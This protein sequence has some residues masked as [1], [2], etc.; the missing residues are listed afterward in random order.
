ME[1]KKNRMQRLEQSLQ[2]DRRKNNLS[3]RSFV[4]L[5]A[6]VY[7]IQV[8]CTHLFFYSAMGSDTLPL[9]TTKVILHLSWI[10]Q[11]FFLQS[12]CTPEHVFHVHFP[13]VLAICYVKL[14]YSSIPGHFVLP[15]ISYPAWYNIY[16]LYERQCIVILLCSCLLYTS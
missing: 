14:Q 1:F 2:T 9:P 10:F 13:C 4:H 12:T 7:Y 5:T 16:F 15:S 8:S 3:K 6:Y 11:N